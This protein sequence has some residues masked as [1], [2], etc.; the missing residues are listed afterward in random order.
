MKKIIPLVFAAVVVGV[1]VAAFRAPAPSSYLFVWAG[2]NDTASDFLAVIDADPGSPH[3]GSVVTSL[4]VG[5]AGTHPHHTEAVMP[6]DGHLLANGF[7]AGKTWLFDLTKPAAPRILTSFGDL[8][9]FSH[10]HTY[11]RLADNTILATFQYAAGAGGMSMGPNT[12]GGLVHM[13]ER[14]HVL[15]TGSARDSAVSERLISPYS[16]LPIPSLNVAVSTTTD[17]DLTDTAAN[18]WVQLWRLSDLKLQKSIALPP[19]PAGKENQLTGEPFLLPDGHSVYIHTFRCGLYLLRGVET[20]APSAE[21]VKTFAGTPCG[22]PILTGHWWIQ[23]VSSEHKLVALDV[24]DAEHPREVS[25]A[26]LGDD[27]SPHWMAIDPTGRRLVVNSGGYA[28]G[29]RLFIVNFDPAT[30]TLSVDSEFKDPGASVPGLDLSHRTWPHGYT[31]RAAPHGAV[32][33][34]PVR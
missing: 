31:G 2:A 10:P 32:F 7:H 19:G 34:L 30:G 22:V 18:Q 28:K 4:A 14:G 26:T 23:T 25:E 9:G 24:S 15:A 1:A 5:A 33:S 11:V 13:D 8:G 29:D 12:T 6:A 3:Y 21:L 27:E 20:G 17:M 16:V